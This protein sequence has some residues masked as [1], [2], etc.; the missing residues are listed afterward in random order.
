MYFDLNRAFGF[1]EALEGG[2]RWEV[3]TKNSLER[4]EEGLARDDAYEA[5]SMSQG[6]REMYSSLQ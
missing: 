5:L 4:P 2:E 1:C 6:G 3:W